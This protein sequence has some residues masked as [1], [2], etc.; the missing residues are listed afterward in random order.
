MRI[1]IGIPTPDSVDPDFGLG[2]LQEIIAH[3]RNAIKGVEIFVRYQTGVRTDKNR[4]EI[5]ADF[6]EMKP[7]LDY[8][9]WLDTDMIYPVDIIERYVVDGNKMGRVD[10]IG[11][12]Y[13]KRS[14]PYQPIGY[15]DSG[16]PETPYSP[17]LPQG[18]DHGKIYEN[19]T[20]LGFGGM[21]VGIHVYEKLGKK[22]WMNYGKSF[23][24][25]ERYRIG[26]QKNQG[27]TH[28]LEFCKL[29]KNN[30]FNIWLHG[31]VRP[32][33][34]GRKKVT[35]IDYIE[36]DPI[37][38]EKFPKVLVVIPTTDMEMA[39][40]AAKVMKIRANMPCDVILAEDKKRVGYVK[41]VNDAFKQADLWQYFVYT[42]QDAYCGHDW[43]RSALIKQASTGAGLVAFN[44]GRWHGQLAAFG[45]VDINWAKQNYDGDLFY[46]KYHSHY[47]DTELSQIAKQQ[48]KYTYEPK[49]LM[50]EVDYDK[51]VKGH[52]NQDDKKLYQ[53]RVKDGFGGK[54]VKKDLLDQFS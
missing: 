45:L 10:L 30:G 36:S 37:I 34:I 20:G 7:K 13:F 35:E 14:E 43:L 53:D 26:R 23:H 4:N 28:D 29:C 8:I 54:V 2:N 24:I 39:E 50:L 9:L 16:N 21:M 33:H 51:D 49:S 40:K 22:K 32:A 1:G 12:L 3:A 42:A 11:C 18:I 46:P 48:R 47:C 15:I 6:I 25:P 19:V 38:I 44:N 27:L 52:I 5:L 17:V 41:T 31:S